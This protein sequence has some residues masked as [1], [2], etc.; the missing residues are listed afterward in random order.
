MP[1]EFEL[2]D[3]PTVAGGFLGKTRPPSHRGLHEAP[4]LTQAL[5]E[6]G[7]CA[8]SLVEAEQ[9]HS[10]RIAVVSTEMLRGASDAGRP[11]CLPGMDGLITDEPGIAL[12]IYVA[13]CLAIY[14]HHRARP[15][16][17]LAHAGWRG[18][19]DGVAGNLA[20]A[21]LDAYGGKPADLALILSPCIGPCCFEVGKEVAA[22][23]EAVPGAVD[24]S[25]EGPHVDLRCVAVAQLQ[26]I[27][28]PLQQID[29][30]PECTRCNPDRFASYRAEGEN[31]GTNVAL[32]ALSD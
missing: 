24:R 9:V 10:S 26:G 30:R 13:D 25:R 32:I 1:W 18:L 6:M 4:D 27:G 29:A 28:V 11:L 15:A 20:R 2:D 14:L 31:S 7:A 16:V 17:G 19:A 22:Q 12:A 21:A 8:R 5:A 3:W 23:F